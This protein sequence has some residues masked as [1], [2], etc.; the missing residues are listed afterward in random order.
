[1]NLDFYS[2][3]SDTWYLTLTVLQQGMPLF[4]SK[5]GS[6]GSNSTRTVMFLL[7]E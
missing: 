7:P 2:I 6:P 5:V 4:S 3:S 1:L